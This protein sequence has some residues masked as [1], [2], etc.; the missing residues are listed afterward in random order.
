M[1]KNGF[2]SL[3]RTALMLTT[4]LVSL[5]LS[6]CSSHTAQVEQRNGYLVNHSYRAAGQDQRVRFLIMH[7]TA[8]DDTQSLQV[9]THNQV[10]AHY[11]IPTRLTYEDGKP[12]VLQLV[13][14]NSRAWHAGISSW[15][16]RNS[17]NDTSIGIEIVNPGFTDDS[18]G[19]RHWYPYNEPQIAAIAAVAKDIIARYHIEPANVLGHSDIA[20]LRKQDPG[21]L[22]PWQRL[23]AMGIGAWPDAPTVEKYLAGRT[24]HAPVNVTVLQTL[25][26][27]YGYDKIPQ[28]GSDDKATRATI[29]AF[30]MHFRPADISGLPDAETEAIVRALLEKYR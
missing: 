24:P 25:L 8:L 16:G 21:R 11:L 17:L 28:D 10:S 26:K 22:F 12:I 13:D 3:P 19:V 4:T 23:A 2:L 9:L 5:W 7:Y 14:E 6:G 30:Q 18:N 27:Q 1:H 29:S 15:L 20:P